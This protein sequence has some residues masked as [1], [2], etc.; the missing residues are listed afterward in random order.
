[1]KTPGTVS[2]KHE[3]DKVRRGNGVASGPRRPVL[4]QWDCIVHHQK[5]DSNSTA[6]SERHGRLGKQF[7]LHCGG[8]AREILS[9]TLARSHRIGVHGI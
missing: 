5:E 7:I 2:K 8:E 9:A 6:C 4:Y 1:M 3:R